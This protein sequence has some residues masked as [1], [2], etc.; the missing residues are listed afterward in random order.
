M[1]EEARVGQVVSVITVTD[2]DLEDRGR[3]LVTITGGNQAAHFTLDSVGS[4]QVLRVGR[5]LYRDTASQYELTIT[6]EDRGTP[7]RTATAT[8]VINVESDN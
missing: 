1:R 5:E 6:A 8:L 7:P 3:A 4:V 2:R